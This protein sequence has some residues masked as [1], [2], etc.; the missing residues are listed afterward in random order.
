M[1]SV[2]LA[3]ADSTQF[4]FSSSNSPSTSDS[5]LYKLSFPTSEALQDSI[6]LHPDA[7][8]WSASYN[9]TS[10]SWETILSS[11][12]PL[13]LSSSPSIQTLIPSISD[14][15]SEPSQNPLSL[16]LLS[17]ASVQNLTS[18]NSNFANGLDSTI[19]DT[20]HP[21]DNVEAIFDEFTRKWGERWIRKDIIGKSWEG[22]EINAWTI[23]DFSSQSGN[24]SVV[25]PEEREEDAEF[26]EDDDE[27][28]HLTRRKK[29][30][31]KK[32]QTKEKIGVVV[33]GALH[34]REW[35]STSTILYLIHF[36][37][38]QHHE[39]KLVK[40]LLGRVEF[41][42]IPILNPDGYAYTW[43]SPS[44]R[45][46]RKSRQPPS[47]PS[48][49]SASTTSP[50]ENT[51]SLRTE[52]WGCVGIDL[53][54]NW[55]HSTFS[56]SKP[57]TSCSDS[58]AG[59]A[60]FESVELKSLSDWLLEKSSKDPSERGESARVRAVLDLHSFGEQLL[61]PYS[62]SCSHPPPTSENLF[63]CLLTGSKAIKSVHGRSWQVGESCQV[64][65]KGGG[66][67]L[68]W[69]YDN[70]KIPWSFTAQLRGGIYGFLLPPTQIRASGEE[71]A[72]ALKAISKFI[73]E[74]Y[75]RLLSTTQRS[76]AGATSNATLRRTAATPSSLSSLSTSG[77]SLSDPSTSSVHGEV[78]QGRSTL[79]REFQF[80]DFD[81]AWGFMSRVALQAEKLNHHPEWSNV[82]N[83]VKITLT[84]HDEGNSLSQLDVKLA[85]RI[86]SIAEDYKKSDSPSHHHQPYKT[87]TLSSS[88]GTNTQD[89][90]PTSTV[91]PETSSTSAPSQSTV[92]PTNAQHTAST[93]ST[94]KATPSSTSSTTST[95]AG[96]EG[97]E[98][99]GPT[100]T[101][102]LESKEGSSTT[103]AGEGAASGT[104]AQTEY[105]P[106]MH[107]GKAGLGPHYND[108]SGFADQVK[109][110]G[111]ILKGKL[112]HNPE[113][114]EQG[115]LRE[116]GALAAQAR[117]AD[118]NNDND[119]PFARPDDGESDKKPE[120][121]KAE[122][123]KETG[124]EARTAAATSGTKSI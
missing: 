71:F 66:E 112:T 47:S 44:N 102:N 56:P 58:Y 43:T 59:S 117:K 5:T 9:S 118:L 55:D 35:I 122:D 119:S 20:Y 29:K 60:A 67:G 30:K 65:I 3:R 114:V 24:K 72:Q 13:T 14:L 77:W 8:I 73:V 120:N 82:Y 116:S 12:S 103:Q 106:Q 88:T 54:K 49:T 42:F 96:A 121:P 22:R 74:M 31:G 97:A 25:E 101:E 92:Q 61:Y 64:G 36:L 41:T 95:T 94:E 63:E 107:A 76:I 18:S 2:T 57:G 45:L 52:D 17:T 6:A 38:Q 26:D 10:R 83:K 108:G 85:E 69:I 53:N 39:D 104:S 48:T 21:F 111:E 19:H 90:A 34:S 51:S 27:V 15:L 89:S 70:A 109:A 4:H 23:S 40:D 98:K 80:K 105:P 50:S 115:H 78:E 1:L 113:L 91:T 32:H 37:L 93:A 84:T 33:Y 79:S 68:D 86:S 81:Q 16:S 7:D 11:D 46:W 100:S 62:S 75:R 87:E 124:H 28:E 110:K 123:V 99:T